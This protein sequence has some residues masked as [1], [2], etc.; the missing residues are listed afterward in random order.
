MYLDAKLHWHKHQR[1]ILQ[2]AQKALSSL[3]RTSYS[4]WGFPVL[5]A[6]LVYTAILRSVLSYAVGIWFNPLRKSSNI[7]SLIIFQ[8]KCL[9]LIGG[10][11][12]ATPSFLLESELF[13]LPLDLYFKFRTA[14]FLSSIQTSSLKDF[15]DSTFSTISSYASSLRKP[16]KKSSTISPNWKFTWLSQ[17]TTNQASSKKELQILFTKEWENQWE[18]KKRKDYAGWQVFCQKPHYNNLK[19][20]KELQKA[21]ASLLLQTRTGRIGLASFLFRAGVP[22]FPTPLCMCGQAEETLKYI[23][24]SCS[25]YSSQRQ[26]ALFNPQDFTTII[27]NPELLQKFLYWFMSLKRLNQFN[28][29]FKLHYSHSNI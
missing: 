1:I 4:T 19:L 24:S 21:E 5:T 14:C 7:S 16:L 17:I 27:S 8:N 6:R 10:A 15:L 18:E 12:K 9:R 20:Y 29:A 28:L 23:T 25:L 22:D 2:K 13:L 3:S 11:F 26:H